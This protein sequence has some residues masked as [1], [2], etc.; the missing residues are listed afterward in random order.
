MSYSPLNFISNPNKLFDYNFNAFI[1]DEALQ[2][3]GTAKDRRNRGI[4]ADAVRMQVDKLVMITSGNNGYSLAKLARNSNIKVVCVIDRKLP[5]A[6][7]QLL[8]KTAY[9]VVEINLSS[10]IYKTEEIISFAREFDSEVIWDVTN[11][12]ES[13]YS[14]IMR[15]ILSKVDPTYVVAPV[16]SGS[17]YVG[18]VDFV[19]TNHLPIKVI[20][21]GVKQKMSSIAD[22]LT[23]PWSPYE[24]LM[25][26]YISLGHPVLH[27]DEDEIV[28][29]YK[30]YSSLISCEPSSSIVFAAANHI[31]FNESDN[32]VFINSG[33]LKK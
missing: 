11:G 26:K 6:L 7:K 28:S 33:K 32:V 2:T 27:I 16:G 21:V 30:K 3:Y 9:H 14:P 8:K 10:K 29:S 22:K 4:M 20:G 18:L 12:F 24:K 25:D 1:K 17:L 23:T 31:H 19:I 15:E 5:E 13:F